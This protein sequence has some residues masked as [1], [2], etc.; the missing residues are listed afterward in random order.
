MGKY[1][2]PVLVV[3]L[4]LL[5]AGAWVAGAAVASPPEGVL[6]LLQPANRLRASR[7]ASTSAMYFFISYPNCSFLDLLS[8]ILTCIYYNILDEM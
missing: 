1:V 5:V 8:K 4:S 7:R 6:P 2:W 3:A